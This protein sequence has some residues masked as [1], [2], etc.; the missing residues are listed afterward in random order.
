MRVLIVED[1]PALG[2]ALENA[3]RHNKYSPE[4]ADCGEDAISA[5]QA[6]AFDAV[7]LDIGLPDMTGID[8]L[9]ALRKTE[10]HAQTPVLLLTAYDQVRHKVEGLDAGA[11]D[12]M[13]KPYNL[14][15]LLAR[16]RV[17]TR[18]RT[19]GASNTLCV[20]DMELDTKG[21]V[22]H[23][24]DVSHVLG[25]H[26]FKVMHLL[27]RNAGQLFDK[28]RLEEEIYGWGGEA[29]SN[30]IEAIVYSLRRKLGRD[31]I[32]TLRGSGYMVKK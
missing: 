14:D 28:A 12:Y 3:L 24:G 20:R 22:V 9:E 17:L 11:D 26:E 32:V 4:L 1:D 15:E 30:T 18:R 6:G 25:N 5:C 16:L 31:A 2:Q 13:T 7:V 10:R 29:E 21:H 19:G 23:R 27:M 8:V